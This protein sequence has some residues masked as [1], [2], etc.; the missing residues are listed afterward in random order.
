[1]RCA[2]FVA[3]ISLHALPGAF[4]PNGGTKRGCKF[5]FWDKFEQNKVLCF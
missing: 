5:H 1:M 2:P 3:A 4:A